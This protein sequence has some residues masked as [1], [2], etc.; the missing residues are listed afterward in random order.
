MAVMQQLS[1]FPEFAGPRR[2]HAGQRRL[3]FA[4]ARIVG[5]RDEQLHDLAERASDYRTRAISTLTVPE[6][7]RLIGLLKTLERNAQ[8]VA[9]DRQQGA[10]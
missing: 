2:A 9:K 10:A 7:R 1:L 6:A 3:I 4:T 8:G 5:L